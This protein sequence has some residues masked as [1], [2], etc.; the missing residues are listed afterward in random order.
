[1]ES[2][3]AKAA[4]ATPLHL[5]TLFV[6]DP[7]MGEVPTVAKAS[8]R[9]VG[10]GT[11]IDVHFSGLAS[12]AVYTMWLFT[13]FAAGATGPSDGSENVFTSSTSGEGE[14]TV[15]VRPTDQGSFSGTSWPSCIDAD[16]FNFIV[17]D[18]HFDG[19]SHGGFPFPDNHDL[20]AL[21]P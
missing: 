8:L 19:L 2:P 11:L 6:I 4:A 1:M 12:K 7:A 21:L 18:G 14:L 9:C 5:T 16:N 15:M 10:Q 3:A 13:T 17:I 20:L